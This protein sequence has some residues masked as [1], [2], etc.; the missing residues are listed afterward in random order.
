[1]ILLR[2]ANPFMTLETI[3][4]FIRAGVHEIDVKIG[5][6]IQKPQNLEKVLTLEPNLPFDSPLSIIVICYQHFQPCFQL[7]LN[8]V[9]IIFH[10]G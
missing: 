2:F 9:M 8:C 6:N 1:M 4:L 10:V 5:G 3:D 7:A